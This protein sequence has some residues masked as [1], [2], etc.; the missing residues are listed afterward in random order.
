MLKLAS[1]AEVPVLELSASVYDV[2]LMVGLL[3]VVA[4]CTGLTASVL[5]MFAVY[6]MVAPGSR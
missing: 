1:T 4:S 2:Q 5:V 6:V 3:R